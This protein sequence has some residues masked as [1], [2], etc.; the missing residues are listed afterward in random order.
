MKRE[1]RTVG[2][3]KKRSYTKPTATKLTQK[4]AKRFVL[5]RTGGSNPEAEEVLQ[6][7]RGE[8]Q[9]KNKR[10]RKAS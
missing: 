1:G 2:S 4:R 9:P 8:Q 6:S 10:F 7:L 5:E 3:K